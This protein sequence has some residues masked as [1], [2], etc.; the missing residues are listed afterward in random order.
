MGLIR[1][2]QSLKI[3]FLKYLITVGIGLACAIILAILTFTAF[4]NVGLII[5]ADH[6]ENLILKRKQEISNAKEFNE[7]LIP[8]GARY[9]FLSPNGEMIK[10]NMDA[11]IQLKAKNFHNRKGISTPSSSFIEFKRSDGYVVIN[12]S[13]EPHY[14]NDWMEKHFP[15]INLLL[16]FLLII[17]CFISTFVAT[18]IWAKRITRQLSPMLEVSDKIANQELDFDIGSSNIREFNDAPIVKLS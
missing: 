10:T 18:L 6:T 7:A 2:G 14:N 9:M 4:Y 5:P 15:S 11:T 13:V 12:Y 1:K 17:F 16:S 3:V 8:N